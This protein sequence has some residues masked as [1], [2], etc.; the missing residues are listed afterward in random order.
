L[1]EAF[2]D[3]RLFPNEA[4]VIGAKK[5]INDFSITSEQ[6]LATFTNVAQVTPAKEIVNQFVSLAGLVNVH[7]RL[8]L[9]FSPRG[10]PDEDTKAAFAPVDGVWDYDGPKSLEALKPPHKLPEGSLQ[11]ALEDRTRPTS[12]QQFSRK[13]WRTFFLISAN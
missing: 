8:E 9:R 6:V 11:E 7:P 12:S 2:Q 10:D 1:C 5:T 3:Q 4:E 13:E